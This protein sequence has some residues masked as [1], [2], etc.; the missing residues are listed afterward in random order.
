LYKEY[1]AR[2][3]KLKKKLKKMF[4][5]ASQPGWPGELVKKSPEIFPNPFFLQKPRTTFTKTEKS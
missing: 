5:I 1:G 2:V 4:L 3:D